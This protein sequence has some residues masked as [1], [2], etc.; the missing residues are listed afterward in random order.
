[1][2]HVKSS[3]PGMKATIASLS[4]EADAIESAT[5]AARASSRGHSQASKMDIDR[6]NHL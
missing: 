2:E 4:E 6:G 1:M 3:M 5:D